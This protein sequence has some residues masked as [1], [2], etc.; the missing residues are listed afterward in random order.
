MRTTASVRR[1]I[2]ASLLLFAVS[3][4]ALALKP[5]HVTPQGEVSRVRQ[6]VV[7]FDTEA[8]MA[9]QPSAPAPYKITCESG[10][11]SVKIPAHHAAWRNAKT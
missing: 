9:G 4:P 7:Q 8:V 1:R 5:V 11:A 10:N 3:T 2:A 6:F